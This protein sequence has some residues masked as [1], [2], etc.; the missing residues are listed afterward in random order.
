MEH[1]APPPL[2]F[3]YLGRRDCRFVL[4]RARAVPLTGF[5][6]VYPFDDAPEAVE[7]LWRALNHPD[8]LPNLAFAAKSYG[9]GALKAEPRQL[10]QLLIP[11]QVLREAGLSGY[12]RTPPSQISEGA[13]DSPL[14]DIKMTL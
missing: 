3:A 1:R 7:K 13:L 10:D 14:N 9:S 12:A 5:L 8:T 6:C 2:L 11:S 4:N